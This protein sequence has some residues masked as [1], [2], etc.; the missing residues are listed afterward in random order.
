[1]ATVQMPVVPLSRPTRPRMLAVGCGDTRSELLGSVGYE[2]TQGCGIEY[3]AL[4]QVDLLVLASAPPEPPA[5]AL[6]RQLRQ[7][8]SVAVMA[9]VERSTE[10]QRAAVVAAGADDCMDAATDDGTLLARIAR[11][12]DGPSPPSRAGVPDALSAV[13]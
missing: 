9:L 7:R 5:S 12:L 3:A 6:V 13:S 8:S 1:M 2:V 4:A 11:L 10:A